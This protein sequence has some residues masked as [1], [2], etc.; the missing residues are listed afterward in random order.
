VVELLAQA[1][2]FLTA[3]RNFLQKLDKEN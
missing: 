2:E 3:V 1:R